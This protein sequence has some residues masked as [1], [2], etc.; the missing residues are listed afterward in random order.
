M[1]EK[2][3]GL[4]ERAEQS[5]RGLALALARKNP[6]AQPAQIEEAFDCFSA[7][8]SELSAAMDLA[9]AGPQYWSES[10]A[11]SI[12]HFSKKVKDARTACGLARNKGPE[13]L[14]TCLEEARRLMAVLK[15]EAKNRWRRALAVK[16]LGIGEITTTIEVV[17]DG[18]L[19]RK[20]PGGNEW[21]SLAVKKA[22]SFPDRDSA[23]KYCE[24]CYEYENFLSNNLGIKTPYAEHRL[25][26]GQDGRW[27]VYNLQERLPGES[28]ACIIIQVAGQEVIDRLVLRILAE[29]K[30][31][32][33]WNLAHPEYLVGFDGQIP[34]WAFIRFGPGHQTIAEDEPLLYLDTTTPFIR[35]NGQEQLDAKIFSKSIPVFLRP[36]IEATL[37]GEVIDRYYRPRDVVLDL[38]ASF[39]THHRPDQ[40]PRMV[41]LVNRW[42]AGEAAGLGLKPFAQ[43]EIFSYNRQ[44]VLIWKFFRQMKRLDR[45][46]TEKILRGKYEQRLPRGSPQKWENLVGAGGKGLTIPESLKPLVKN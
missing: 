35:K 8:L 7:S 44:D 37:M 20:K 23:Q 30:K 4:I 11:R 31:L 10:S 27:L 24:V 17:G 15:D 16:I 36:I 29:F 32:F 19:R 45:F 26:P 38:I 5:R 41:A 3:A 43:K 34:N 40:V 18:A 14:K 9:G 22:P 6:P 2:L 33:E 13:Q 28:I 12:A 39:I 46:V 21:V 1:K 25:V 42:L